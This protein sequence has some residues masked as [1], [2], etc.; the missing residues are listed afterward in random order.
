M[1][2]AISSS[3]VRFPAPPLDEKTLD[4]LEEMV[5]LLGLD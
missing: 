2:D 3:H 5:A 1:R 4:E